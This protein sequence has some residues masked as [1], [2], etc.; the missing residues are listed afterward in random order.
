MERKK[1]RGSTDELGAVKAAAWA[2]YQRGSGV[3][4]KQTQEF[5][6]MRTRQPPGPS[7]FKQ[8][9]MR[10]AEEVNRGS[11]AS[12]PIHTDASLL[13]A[14]E[15]ESLSRR[16]DCILG[17][18]DSKFHRKFVAEDRSPQKNATQASN[19][20]SGLNKKGKKTRR[21]WWRH[22][23]VCGTREDV[24]DAR[25]FRDSRRPEKRAPVVMLTTCR[26]RST[27]AR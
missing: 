20:A 7:L 25:G 27:R 5:D 24:E 22:A 23:V 4:G 8:E 19:D 1:P 9:A 11:Q 12:S 2:W 26:P 15:I 14:Y 10:I 18:S 3:E 6:L 13:D 16:L 17:S 21:C